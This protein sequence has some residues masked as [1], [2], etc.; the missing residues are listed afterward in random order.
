MANPFQPFLVSGV[1]VGIKGNANSATI[2]LTD[3][4]TGESITTT[5]DSNG[6]YLFDLANLASGYTDGDTISIRA[7]KDKEGRGTVSFTLNVTDG[8]KDINT[9]MSDREGKY[10]TES[11]SIPR[12]R[13]NKVL[14]VNSNDEEIG[15]HNP[16]S[17]KDFGAGTITK[18][19][20][21]ASNLAE[22]IG[23][24]LP[25]TLTSD[26]RWRISR[27]IYNASNLATDT[28]FASGRNAF[29]FVWNDRLTY[30]YE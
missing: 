20:Y 24:A 10:P 6:E 3:T 2:T 5:A 28:L 21:N 22:Y 4:T 25:G 15:I 9:Y 13:L 19:A 1:A 17:V 14:L 12:F 23:E 11:E 27:I 18:V 29:E 26:A 8:F 16:L 7:D 30:N